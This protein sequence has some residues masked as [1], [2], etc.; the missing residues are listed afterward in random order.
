MQEYTQLRKKP[1]TNHI[2]IMFISQNRIPAKNFFFDRN[3]NDIFR[4]F[5]IKTDLIGMVLIRVASVRQF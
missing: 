4:Y 5:S 2:Y 3:L 1:P